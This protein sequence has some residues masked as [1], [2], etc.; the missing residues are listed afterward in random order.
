MNYKIKYFKYKN[1]YLNIKKS[2]LYLGGAAQEIISPF[3]KADIILF[4]EFLTKHFGLFEEDYKQLDTIKL[5]ESDI[6]YNTCTNVRD[7]L[8]LP[9]DIHTSIQTFLC[10]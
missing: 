10:Y 1:K 3:T 9:S 8:S 7:K 5:V 6:F 4:K 2:F